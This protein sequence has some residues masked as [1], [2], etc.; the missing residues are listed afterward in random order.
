MGP[1]NA[2][3]QITNHAQMDITLIWCSHHI[4]KE[5]FDTDV[6]LVMT[7]FTEI[8]MEKND[9]S[10]KKVQKTQMDKEWYICFLCMGSKLKKHRY[11]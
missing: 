1:E 6:L 4:F 5:S 2:K 10:L 3:Q 11:I 9:T 8:P 7:I